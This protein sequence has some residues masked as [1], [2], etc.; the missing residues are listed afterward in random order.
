MEEYVFRPIGYVR[1]EAK[2]IPRHWSISEIEGY[3][4]IKP[5]YQEGLRDFKKG[6]KVVVLFVFHQ[7]SPF[8][9]EKL[10]QKPPHSQE[11]KG[12]F[13]TCSPIRPNPI[14]LSV[15]EVLEVANNK[16]KVK[17][18]DMFDGTPILDLK[19][20]KAYQKNSV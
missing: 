1:T 11:L 10:L 5:E 17:G 3:L 19:P 20:F 8:T 7:S 13:S 15:L 4:E 9:P 18:I 14:G 2:E 12:V 16:V 6:D